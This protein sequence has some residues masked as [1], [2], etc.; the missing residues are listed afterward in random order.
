VGIARTDDTNRGATGGCGHELNIPQ[1][2]KVSALPRNAV[3][4]RLFLRRR[5]RRCCG[6]S[7]SSRPR[8]ADA[9]DVELRAGGERED[10]R[11]HQS[12]AEK[13]HAQLLRRS[14]LFARR[15]FMLSPPT[16]SSSAEGGFDRGFDRGGVSQ[17]RIVADCGLMIGLQLDGLLLSRGRMREWVV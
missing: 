16:S 15:L 8:H 3:L 17:Y 1:R 7:F 12:S 9:K 14:L 13:Q 10:S 6:S 4:R 2:D 5:Y 11:K